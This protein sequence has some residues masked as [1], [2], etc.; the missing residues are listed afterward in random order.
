MKKIEAIVREEKLDE[1]KEAFE[2]IDIY[3]MTVVDVKG[4]GS[5]RGISLQ[6]RAG[7]Y[8]V[9]FL[10]KKMIILVIK[11]DDVQ[12]VVN[13]ICEK[14]S[15][16]QAGDGKIFISTIDEVV[17]IRTRETGEEVL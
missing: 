3:G 15:T 17:R 8:R 10:P 16:S 9:D 5:Q 6:W 11:D 7:E 13:I 4:R 14:G 1:I 2:N 12:R